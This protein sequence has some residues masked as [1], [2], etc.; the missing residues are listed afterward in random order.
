[1]NEPAFLL[2]SNICIYLLKGVSAAARAK[3]EARALGEVLTSAVAYAEVM[4]GVDPDDAEAQATAK[5][6]FAV[7]PV[8]PFDMA[9]ADAYARLP[10][11]R[12]SF[13]RLIAAHAVAAGLTLITRNAADFADVPELVVEDWTR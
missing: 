6:F 7:I 5:R 1:V 11:K 4:L 8:R 2:D 9:A 13:D 12:R 3:L 10:F